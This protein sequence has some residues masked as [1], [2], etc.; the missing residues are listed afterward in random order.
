MEEIWKDVIG[1]EG[2]YQVSSIGRV[3]R[4]KYGK[5]NFLSLP[6]LRT[7]Y[8]NI[9]LS[10]KGIVKN[11][12][13]H[14]V[15]AEAFI[16]KDYRLK[17]LVVNHKNFKRDDN[18]LEN[19]EVVT[20]REN[21]NQKHLPSSSKYTGVSW[22]KRKQKWRASI[23][24]N[25][26]I[27]HLGVFNDEKEASEYYEAALI[28]V[29]EGRI[30]DILIKKANFSSKYKGVSFDK[31]KNKWKSFIEINGKSKYLGSFNYEKEAS[32]YY[33]S[34]LICVKEGR[35]YD[36]VVKKHNTSSKYKGVSF[37]KKYN[38]WRSRYEKNHIRKHIGYFSTEEDAKIALD[39]YKNEKMQSL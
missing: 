23:G 21:N 10:K 2:L 35:V 29:N 5:E 20:R 36:I 39:N 24:I 4:L 7:G 27:K 3:K 1:Y 31:E 8:L 32:D 14:S 11:R 33:Q 19:L 22:Q 26:K 25:G 37:Y 6:K 38:K 15:M 30:E 34:A 9:G 16:D 17:G 12:T 18:R 28:C 13:A